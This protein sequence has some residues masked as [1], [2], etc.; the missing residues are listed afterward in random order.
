MSV[1]SKDNKDKQQQNVS[2]GI[3]QISLKKVATFD[4]NGASFENLKSINFNLWG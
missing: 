1:N 3:S 4:E 2:S